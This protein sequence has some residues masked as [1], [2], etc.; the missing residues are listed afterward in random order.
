MQ[1]FIWRLC[2]A[3]ALCL[4]LPATALSQMLATPDQ[5]I[6]VS[7]GSRKRPELQETQKQTFAKHLETWYYD[8]VDSLLYQ[9][10]LSLARAC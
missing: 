2:I 10:L 6:V 4:L 7:V 5:L 8:E 1:L 9:Q 3:V